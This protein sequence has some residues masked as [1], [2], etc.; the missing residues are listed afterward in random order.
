V[1]EAREF[2]RS[3]RGMIRTVRDADAVTLCGCGGY[4]LGAGLELAMACD[5]RVA[6]ADAALGLPEIDVGLVTGIQGGLLIRLVGPQAA[7]ELVYTGDPLSGAE[8]TEL[9]LVNRA[10]PAD[11]YEAAIDDYVDTLAAKSPHV[12]RE[13]KRVFRAWRSA[14]IERGTDHSLESIAACFDTHDQQEAMGAFLEDR[15]PTFEGR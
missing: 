10:P 12:L 4:A 15:E 13:Q 11:E 3:L 9:G 6:T 1:S 8:A 14:G 7:K 5:F 2:L